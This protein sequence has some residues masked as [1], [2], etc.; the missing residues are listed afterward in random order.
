[1]AIRNGKQA[2]NCEAKGIL[3]CVPA[4]PHEKSSGN[5]F[6]SFFLGD[7]DSSYRRLTQENKLRNFYVGSYIQDDVKGHTEADRQRGSSL[8]IMIPFTEQ[9]NNVVYFDP[10]VPNA[11]AVTPGGSPLLGA[12]NKL[13]VSGYDRADIVFTHFDPKVGVAYS[14]NPKTVISS[15]FSINHL[16]GGPY[17]FGNNKLSLQ[18]GTL[19]AGIANVNSNGSNIPGNSQWD[20][21]PLPLPGNTP[22]TTD[23]NSTATARFTPFPKNPGSYPYGE[24]WSLGIQRELPYNMFLSIA[25]AGNRGVHLPSMMNPINQTDPKYLSQFCPSAGVN[26]ANCTMSPN[27]PNFAWTIAVAGGSE[28]GGLLSMPGGTPS[29][30][31]YAPYC[32]FMKDYGA[33]IGMSQAPLPYPQSNPSESCG[34]ICNPFDLNGSSAYKGLQTQLLKRYADGLSVLANY[35]YAKSMSNTDC[36]FACPELWI[37]EPVQ[38]DVRMDG[39]LKLT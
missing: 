11:A 34:C 3:P 7:A 36:D 25:Y 37:F 30:G 20:L 5:A 17:D 12:A 9:N 4:T 38:L 6:A 13:G 18:Y 39:F 19:F 27:S 10:T 28:G 32:N 29:A 8:D 21:N 16:N 1:M 35:T 26:D 14:I 2:A 24:Y 33:N 22:F 15:G 31:F 23:S